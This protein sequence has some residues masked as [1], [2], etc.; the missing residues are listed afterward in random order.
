MPTYVAIRNLPGITSDGLVGAGVRIKTCASGMCGEGT[1][2]RWLRS[3][4]LPET[5]QTHC[6]FEAPSMAAVREL[7]ERAALPYERL[8]EVAEMTP[9]Q[10]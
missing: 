7:N 6:Y 3:Y 2:V 8:V 4:F 5:S 10:V 9:A 1:P